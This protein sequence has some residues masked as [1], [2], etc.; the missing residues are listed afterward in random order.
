MRFTILLLILPFYLQSQRADDRTTRFVWAESGL[1]MRVAGRA[2]AEKLLT[3][4][5]GAEVTLLDQ[6]GEGSFVTLYAN[7]S[8]ID[9]DGE[10]WEYFGYY[11]QVSFAGKTGFVHDAY[12]SSWSPADFKAGANGYSDWLAQ[13][14]DTIF[15]NEPTATG[16]FHEDSFLYYSGV[17]ISHYEMKAAAGGTIVL[18]NATFLEGF[19]F[20][21][22]YFNL[23]VYSTIEPEWTH[24]FLIE[25]SDNQL[26]FKQDLLEVTINSLWGVVVIT[27]EA[28]C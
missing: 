2:D 5:F 18:P 9:G 6:S 28:S 12:L 20:A 22:K 16:G 23:D 1:I 27:F 13:P 19:H 3:I 14:L 10:G 26:V 25:Q 8:N 15:I 7:R 24:F 17:T 21:R 4:P 11:Q